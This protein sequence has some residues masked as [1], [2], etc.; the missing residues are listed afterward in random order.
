MTSD[1]TAKIANGVAACSYQAI[2]LL[3]IERRFHGEQRRTLI[4]DSFTNLF[5]MNLCG[6]VLEM[7]KG[8]GHTM[9]LT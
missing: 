7:S 9:K 3:S 5:L 4:S 2:L 8:G 6:N 1:R